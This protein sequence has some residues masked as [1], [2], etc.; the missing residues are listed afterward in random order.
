VLRGMRDSVSDAHLVLE[1]KDLLELARADHLIWVQRLHSM[2]LGRDKIKE[3]DVADHTQCRLGKWYY[4]RGRQV[5][6]DD[7]AF[8]ALE[9]PHR[10]I[11][12]AAR[13]AVAAWNAGRKDEAQQLV[14]EVGD[15]S[16]EI[17]QLLT[18]VAQSLRGR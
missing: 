16:Q 5:L 2:L 6:A 8:Q 1:D 7:A 3:E 15:I 4:S 9:E 13:K 11:H 14:R 12:A 17:L 18:Q 10:H